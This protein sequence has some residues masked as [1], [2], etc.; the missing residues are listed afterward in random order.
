MADDNSPHVTNAV[1][2]GLDS[3]YRVRADAFYVRQDDGV[4]LGNNTGSFSVRGQGAYQL[5]SSL[6]SNLDGERSLADI[7][8]DLSENARSSVLRL[9]RVLLHNGFIKEVSHPAEPVPDWMRE[10][11]AT[12]LA[13]LEH[14]ADRPVTR[15][16][17]VRTRRVVCAGQGIALHAMLDAL[18]ESG[19]ARLD[20]VTGK[21][22][23]DTAKQSA[24]VPD[25][26]YRWRLH[27]TDGDPLESL[28]DHPACAGADVVLLACDDVT[29]AALGRVQRLLRSRGIPVGVLGHCGPFTT[30]VPPLADA[31]WCWEC[32]YRSIGVP[33]NGDTAGLALSTAPA[34]VGALQLAQQV[35]ALLADVRMPD[36]ESVTTVEPLAPVVRHHTVYQHP[37][38]PHHGR[39][40]VALT[41]PAASGD[42]ERAGETAVPE[43]AV[44]PDIPMP[45]DP[46]E[47]VAVSDRIVVTAAGLTD[48]LTGPLLALG[49]GDL[50]QLPLSASSCRVVHPAGDADR[51]A[52]LRV[53]CRALSPREARNQA[54]L[55][56]ME[57]LATR[58]AELTWPAERDAARYRFGA[59]WSLAEARFRARLHAALDAPAGT[60][61]E[62]A[63]PEERP[64]EGTVLAFLAQ[65]LDS[66]G[67]GARW[68]AGELEKPAHGTV[69]ARITT[70]DGATATGVG[71]HRDQALAHALARAV[72]ARTTSGLGPRDLEHVAFLAPPVRTWAQTEAADLAAHEVT[73]LLPFL[74][75]APDSGS[76]GGATLRVVALASEEV[77]R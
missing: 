9:I 30:A 72:A 39:E 26:G 61:H 23:A 53:I 44:R 38:C 42:E 67:T 69:R 71:T 34:T 16:R 63:G 18:R 41:Q 36:A 29:P 52:A 27:S 49:E 25:S 65:T 57:Q 13:F 68:R 7:Y 74:R 43:T 47:R 70:A 33:A 11:Y 48:P 4:W 1:Q 19:I 15:L 12:H 64:A 35:F 32:V 76:G 22:D 20:V 6:F 55:F 17:Q 10:R 58:V 75:S 77:S 5:V 60:P 31:S 40:A 56:A 54:V 3:T 51:P 66:L 14:H 8:G 28:D 24:Q 45:E 50:S 2:Q 21:E 62:A 73:E 46:P 37:C 59:G